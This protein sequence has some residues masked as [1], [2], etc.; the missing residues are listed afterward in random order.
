MLCSIY[1]RMSKS[2]ANFILNATL[3]QSCHV[4]WMAEVCK[5]KTGSVSVF[6]DCCFP[7]YILV[8]YNINVLSLGRKVLCNKIMTLHMSLLLS[9]R[10]W[11]RKAIVKA[12]QSLF[13]NIGDSHKASF[14]QNGGE[15]NFR[16]WWHVQDNIKSQLE[17]TFIRDRAILPTAIY[18][19]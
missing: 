18:D 13:I 15:D 16:C 8:G 1:K 17:K 6:R 3:V 10:F 12:K 9:V 5:Y 19:W 14:Y 2:V 7:W 11:N 4:L